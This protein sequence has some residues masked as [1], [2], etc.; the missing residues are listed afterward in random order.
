MQRYFVEDGQINGSWIII[1][2]RDDLYHISKVMRFRVGTKLVCVDGKGH[3]YLSEIT[4]IT[5]QA[6]HC[7]VLKIMPSQGEPKTQLIVAQ[8]LPKGERWDWVLQKGTELGVTQFIPFTSERTV[9]KVHPEKVAKKRERW[10]RIVKEAAEQSGRGIIPEVS[11]PISWSELLSYLEK[12]ET[13]WIAYEKG[14]KSLQS[15]M[16]QLST[17]NQ[18][19]LIIGPEGGFSEQEIESAVHAGAIPITL[20]PRILR[21]ET[22]SLVALSCILFATN[23]LGGVKENE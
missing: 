21:T 8:A 5:K 19:V 11:R 15:C 4:Q 14:G 6:V 2:N 1:T 18:I 3:D 16:Q 12:T 17:S 20:G 7:K 10:Q 9:V 13:A 22:A 23:E